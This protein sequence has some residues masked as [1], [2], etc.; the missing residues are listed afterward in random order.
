MPAQV[1]SPKDGKVNETVFVGE[2][3]FPAAPAG[4]SDIP[5]VG[6]RFQSR[7][8]RWKAPCCI[9][10]RFGLSAFSKDYP[11]PVAIPGN[12]D[13]DAQDEPRKEAEAAYSTADAEPITIELQS[14]K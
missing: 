5:K 4:Q 1:Y 3:E 9:A 8:A 14:H 10:K 13:S 7:D 12:S 11:E 2:A 6:L